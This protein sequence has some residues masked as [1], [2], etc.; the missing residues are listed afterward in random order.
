MFE[1]RLQ[2]LNI[3][4]NS[5][6]WAEDM[7]EKSQDLDNIFVHI[8]TGQEVAIHSLL[9]SVFCRLD[10]AQ[11]FT[12][13]DKSTPYDMVFEP[14]KNAVFPQCSRFFGRN[15][16]MNHVIRLSVDHCQINYF[17]ALFKRIQQNEKNKG[18]LF[19]TLLSLCRCIVVGNV[20][21]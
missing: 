4:P 7:F 14:L 6:S 1:E 12:R 5:P 8:R 16:N 18:A 2:S 11:F 20:E 15:E 10:F 9:S 19:V 17:Q 21:D 3:D 13:F